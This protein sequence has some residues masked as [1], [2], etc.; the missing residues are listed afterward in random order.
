MNAYDIMDALN[1]IAPDKVQRALERMGYVSARENAPGKPRAIGRRAR[2]V[3]LAAVLALL[4]AA[5]GYAVGR[6]V[7]SPEQAWQIA[8][9]E[10]AKMQDMGLLSEEFTLPDEPRSV[11]EMPQ[12][13]SGE[14]PGNDYWFGRI[15][16]HRYTLGGG[17]EKFRFNV[18]VDV[19]SGKIT[20][21]SLDAN[22]EAWEEAA[23]KEWTDTNGNTKKSE[24]SANY[25]DLVP[26][27]LTLGRCCELLCEYWGFSGYTL[28]GTVE[29]FYKYDTDAP[30]GD[31]LLTDMANEAYITVYFDGDQKGVPM[32][33][34]LFAYVHPNG[35]HLSIGTNH[36]LG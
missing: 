15:F 24:L 7:N 14:L 16:T 1:G 36:A 22:P 4:L 29:E 33:I 28:S 12:Y 6:A 13:D 20:R 27:E 3:L 31:E 35:V 9:Q 2:M 18:D 5:C 17:T 10:I 8:R 32:Y 30:T 34:E 11:S 21:L 25:D 26:S 19:M 23:V